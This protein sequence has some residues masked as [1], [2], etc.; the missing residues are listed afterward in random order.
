MALRR[1]FAVD[2]VRPRV[3]QRTQKFLSGTV[4]LAK[5][6]QQSVPGWGGTGQKATVSLRDHPLVPSPLSAFFAARIDGQH[7]RMILSQ[8]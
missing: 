8:L 2:T 3:V 6:E 7:T 1:G 5:R 4:Q